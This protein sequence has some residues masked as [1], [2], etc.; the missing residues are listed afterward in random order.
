M[1]NFPAGKPMWGGLLLSLLL[2]A[3]TPAAARDAVLSRAEKVSGVSQTDYVVRWWQWANRVPDGDKPYQ[4]PTGSQCALNQAGD[5]WF[6][7]GTDGTDDAHRHCTLPAGKY[8]FLPV[9]NMRLLET[10]AIAL[11]ALTDNRG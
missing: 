2:A 5:V 8:I 11:R 7:A 6:L 9:I 1:C 4:D 10:A 3:P